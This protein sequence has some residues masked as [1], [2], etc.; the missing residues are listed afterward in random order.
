MAL[1]TFEIMDGILGQIGFG[2]SEEAAGTIVKNVELA[3]EKYDSNET[4]QT[5]TTI[6]PTTYTKELNGM[7]GNFSMKDI[8]IY[9]GGTVVALL[10]LS[11]LF[12]G[13]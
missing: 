7:L 4:K 11:K 10:L 8:L 12:K 3:R 1:D 2:S 5:P 6:A 13:K 9:G